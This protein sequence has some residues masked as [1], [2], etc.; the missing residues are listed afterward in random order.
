MSIKWLNKFYK[1][2]D[3]RGKMGQRKKKIFASILMVVLIFLTPDT[4]MPSDKPGIC[5]IVLY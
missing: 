2:I 5:V 3:L 4:T 1:E